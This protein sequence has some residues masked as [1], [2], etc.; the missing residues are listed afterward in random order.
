MNEGSTDAL[1]TTQGQIAEDGQVR[2]PSTAH[3]FSDDVVQ[4]QVEVQHVLES[5]PA[6]TSEKPEIGV[7]NVFVIHT[8][9]SRA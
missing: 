1:M 2:S 7:P 3:G 9:R 8:K 4:S 5:M 6:A